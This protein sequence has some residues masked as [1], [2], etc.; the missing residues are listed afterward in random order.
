MACMKEIICFGGILW[1]RS[2]RLEVIQKLA[3][4]IE[5]YTID[6]SMGDLRPLRGKGLRVGPQKVHT[7]I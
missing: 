5:I 3:N 6:H 4:D 1:K 2:L 7:L